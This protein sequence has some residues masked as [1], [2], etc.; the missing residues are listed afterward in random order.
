MLLDI[1]VSSD[2]MAASDIVAWLDH[3]MVVVADS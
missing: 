1:V 2:H 3:M